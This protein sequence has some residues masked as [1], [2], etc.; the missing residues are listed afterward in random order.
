VPY[1]A[2]RE[3]ELLNMA[4]IAPESFSQAGL[5]SLRALAGTANHLELRDTET[6][7]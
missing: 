5:T 1:A 7:R 4:G 6:S 2:S 3:V